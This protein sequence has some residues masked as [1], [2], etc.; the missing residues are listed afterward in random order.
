MEKGVVRSAV[1]PMDPSSELK[2]VRSLFR[3]ALKRDLT[4]FSE[5]EI[6]MVS[7]CGT[8]KEWSF[9]TRA[10]LISLGKHTGFRFLDESPVV[11]ALH[12]RK[13]PRIPS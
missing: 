3:A 5:T 10:S 1:T 6:A 13:N 2:G 8:P 4:P 9:S 7:P 11:H 12:D